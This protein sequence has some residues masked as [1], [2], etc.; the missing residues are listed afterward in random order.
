MK[1]KRRVTSIKI[2]PK[3]WSEAKIQAIKEGI[4]VRDLVE[5]ALKRR[6]RDRKLISMFPPFS[7]R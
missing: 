6:M 5:D 3:L 1:I 2:D 7:A 4:L